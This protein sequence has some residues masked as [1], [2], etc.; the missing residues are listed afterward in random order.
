MTRY[1]LDTGPIV[2]LLNSND[3]LH[4]WATEEVHKIQDEAIITCEAV[5][6][7]AFYL[8]KKRAPTG[9]PLLIEMVT[10]GHLETSRSVD[11]SRVGEIMTKYA[12]QAIDYADACV[13]ALTE[14]DDAVVVLT[15]DRKDF[16][17]FRR[18]KTETIPFRA[19]PIDK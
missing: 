14:H 5:L 15:V 6:S 17:I 9:V 19:P 8:L 2:A 13:V 1:I 4:N 18:R 3:R 10:K 11:M 7:E 16:S 12:D